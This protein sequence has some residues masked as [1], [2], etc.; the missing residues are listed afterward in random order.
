MEIRELSDLELDSVSAGADCKE[1]S[2]K[3][4]NLG[5]LGTF[6]VWTFSCDGGRIKGEGSSWVAR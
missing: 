5:I 2:S 3:S 6:T 1:T 4:V